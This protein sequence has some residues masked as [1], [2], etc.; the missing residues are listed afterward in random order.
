MRG[1]TNFARPGGPF[2]AAHKGETASRRDGETASDGESFAERIER[3]DRER[4]A[5]AAV[6]FRQR[7][8]AGD[9]RGL[10]GGRLGEL[11]SQ[12]A[13]DG[14]VADELG[15]LRFVMARL[16]S[17]E[18]DPVV[19]A[20]AISRV[21]AVSIQAARAQRAISGQLAEGLTDAITAILTELDAGATG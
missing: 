7:M 12:A 13:A 1:C 6:E 20:K 16:L 2:C 10:F 3:E 18:D 11:M 5:A 19:L 17:E 9:Y 21:A 8:D 15:A 14:G 4:R